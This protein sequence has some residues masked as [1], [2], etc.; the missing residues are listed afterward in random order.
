MWTFFIRLL[1]QIIE[2]L[3]EGENARLFLAKLSLALAILSFSILFEV[4]DSP[5]LDKKAS[6]NW[7]TSST[8]AWRVGFSSASRYYFIWLIFY[9]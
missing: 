1:A 5:A 6:T 9:L 3:L 4:L 7:P 2:S 8:K